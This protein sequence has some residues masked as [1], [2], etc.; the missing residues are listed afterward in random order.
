[1]KYFTEL[2]TEGFVLAFY[3]TSVNKSIPKTCVEITT[4]EYV[5]LLNNPNSKAFIDGAVVDKQKPI[6]EMSYKEKRRAKYPPVGDQLDAL[7]KGGTSRDAMKVIIDAVKT[8]YP[9]PV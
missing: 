2:D 4:D 3:N 5:E 8:D 6:P 9:K 7:W 1:M